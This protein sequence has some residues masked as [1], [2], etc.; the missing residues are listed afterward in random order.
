MLHWDLYRFVKKAVHIYM[1]QHQPFQ[2]VTKC[3]KTEHINN[4]PCGYLSK[5]TYNV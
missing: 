2:F 5:L 1:Q 4:V 3:S